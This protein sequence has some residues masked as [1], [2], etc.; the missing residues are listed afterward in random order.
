MKLLTNEHRAK[1]LVNGLAMAEAD[2]SETVKPVVKLF[3]PD[4]SATWL[5]A[6]LEPDDPDVAFC[7]ADLGFGCP[8]M[9]SV[10]MSELGLTARGIGSVAGARPLVQGGSQPVRLCQYGQRIRIYCRLTQITGAGLASAV[11]RLSGNIQP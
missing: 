9:G 6:W 1:L 2:I 7:L 10:S 11:P 4:G 3:M 5:L 8:E